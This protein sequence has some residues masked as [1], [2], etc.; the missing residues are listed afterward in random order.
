MTTT[1]NAIF[2]FALAGVCATA[3]SAD[4]GMEALL[5]DLLGQERAA[6]QV[7][8][9]RDLAALAEPPPPRPEPQV[10][11]QAEPGAEAPPQIVLAAASVADPA[12]ADATVL[13]AAAA[14]P[15]AG[16]VAAAVPAGDA[17]WRCLSEALYFEAR[18]ES[19]RGVFA[20][21]EVVLNRRDSG[22]YPRS[23]CGVIDQRGQTGGCQF[24][25]RCDGLSDAITDRAAWDRVGRVA[26]VMLDG[27]PRD[28]TGGATHYHT[29]AVYPSWAAQFPRTTTIGAHQ[30]YRQPLRTAGN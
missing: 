7:A 4:G 13:V 3:A 5:G 8:S 11:P 16:L 29:A 25:Y 17:E 26:R 9:A 14:G 21:A 22:A 10:A 15:Q 27:A 23:V 30:F 2:A 19:L 1:C 6:L 28:L 20:V 24:S 18:G 12:P